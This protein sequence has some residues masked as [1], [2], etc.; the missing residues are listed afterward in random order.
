MQ[1]TK[2]ITLLPL[3]C[4]LAAALPNADALPEAVSEADLKIQQSKKLQVRDA[5]LALDL[6]LESRDLTKRA[7]KYDGCSCKSGTKQG[8]YCYICDQVNYY[9]AGKIAD[10]YECSPSGNCCN[11]GPAT[12]CSNNKQKCNG[13]D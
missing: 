5:D 4:S 2:L 7:C 6:D 8:E 10:L 3:L 13:K 11:Y 12:V 1:L 9:A